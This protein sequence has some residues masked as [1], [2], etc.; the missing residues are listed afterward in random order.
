MNAQ[1]SLIQKFMLYDFKLGHNI[2]E[3]TK[4]H[5]AQKMKVQSKSQMAQEICGF[6]DHAPRQIWWVALKEYQ[7]GRNFTDQ[8]CLLPSQLWQN[9]SELLNC[10]LCYE[11]IAKLMTHPIIIIINIYQFTIVLN[12]AV[13]V[14][15]GSFH[16][17]SVFNIG[18]LFILVFTEFS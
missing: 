1:H 6:W 13:P 15:L 2:T 14:W 18:L 7:V 9:Y 4:K 17:S 5:V 10:A 16:S 3:V 8:C 12:L 11:N